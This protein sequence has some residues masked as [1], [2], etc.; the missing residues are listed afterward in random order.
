MPITTANGRRPL[1][2]LWAD[3]VM[4]SWRR[5]DRAF[6]PVAADPAHH[7][8]ACLRSAISLSVGWN[9]PR[10][11]CGGTIASMASS[12]SVV[13]PRLYTSV[14]VRVADPHHSDTLQL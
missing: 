7:Y 5:L 4:G 11:R 8:E 9:A 2:A 3:P 1:A 13:S 10:R 12:F 6:A 14:V